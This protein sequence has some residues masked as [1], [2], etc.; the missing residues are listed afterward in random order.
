M[1]GVAPAGVSACSTK[2]DCSAL[3][4]RQSAEIIPGIQN[5][6]DGAL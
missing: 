6:I 2:R 4:R 3:D 5:D 1:R